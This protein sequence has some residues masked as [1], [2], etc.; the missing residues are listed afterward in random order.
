MK[1]LSNTRAKR[2][3]AVALLLLWVFAIA[4]ACDFDPFS[5]GVQ[6]TSC[7]PSIFDAGDVVVP[8][9]VNTDVVMGIAIDSSGSNRSDGLCVDTSRFGPLS[10]VGILP[11]S[12]S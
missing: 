1:N 11:D 10:V 8:T 12:G 3:S 4:N 5:I 9:V 7:D 2:N 6:F